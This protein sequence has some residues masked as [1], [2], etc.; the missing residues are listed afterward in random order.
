MEGEEEGEEGRGDEGKVVGRDEEEGFGL[1]VVGVGRDEGQGPA[2]PRGV[3][4][5]EGR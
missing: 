2:D 5:G 4:G 1:E 3:R